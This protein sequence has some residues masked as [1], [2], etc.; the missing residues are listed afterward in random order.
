[1]KL[2]DKEVLVCDCE[3]T[4]VIDGK[5]LAKACQ[6]ALPE[7]GKAAKKGGAKKAAVKTPSLD[8]ATHLCRV[9]LNEFERRAKG[10]T[11]LLVACTQEAPVFLET[12]EEMGEDAPD[13]RFTNIRERAGWSKDAAKKTPATAKMAALLAEAAL[14]IPDAQSVTMIS[15]GV[16]LVLGKDETAIEAAKKV[17]SRL[18]VTVLLEP[19]APAPAPKLMDVPVFTGR[20]TAAQGHLGQFQVTVEDFAPATPSSKDSL[21]FEANAQNGTSVADLILDLRGG[22]PLFTAP[23]KRDGYMNPDPGNPALVADA[24]LELTDMVGEFDKPRYVDYDA[25]ICAH[26]RSGITGCT[27]C[28]DICPTGAITPDGDKVAIDAFVCAGCGTCA[29]VCPTGAAK[30]ALPAGDALHQRLRTLLTA[31]AAAGGGNPQLLVYDSGFGDDVIDAMARHG[32]GLPLNV[33]PFV[34]NQVA[35]VGLDFMLA[36][37]AFGA[38]RVL[39]LLPPGKADE[40]AS[41]ESE[42]ALAEAV[43]DGLG[44]GT[45]RI[46]V[47]EETDP[48]ALEARLYGLEPLN[49]MPVADFL[50]MGRKRAVMSLALA[51]L[52]AA[53]PNKVDTIALP[54]GAPFGAVEVDIPGCTVCLACVGACPT[55]ALRDNPDRPQLSFAEEACVQCGLCK[56]TC[57]EKVISLT[58]RL[59]FLE[60]ARTHQLVKEEEP[61][62]CIRCGKPFGA[63]ST[64]EN[65][66]KKLEGHA[67]FQDKGGVE[68]LKMCEDCRVIAI[69]EEDA[70]P[71]AGSARP[72]VRT[73][74]DYLRERDELREVA[75][76]DMKEK[77]LLPE[78]GGEDDEDGEDGGG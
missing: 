7:T 61:F 15:G 46:Q 9:Q 31:Y 53:A 19:G 52:H 41:L 29:S 44:Y 16:L 66:V 14:D 28:L 72:T 60:S 33:L 49:G 78:G 34:V 76:R 25:N 42:A 35:L 45:G 58:P 37:A 6:A 54:E 12:L 69:A 51:G 18:D 70:H 63:R 71:L 17:A 75:A 27:K 24:L 59:S 62:E 73:T 2:N 39:I 4:M 22:T 20:V 13:A 65:M 68:R 50:P 21:V 43:F 47:V 8:V 10:E 36:A 38:E 67:M 56:N 57:P 48:D 1:M 40:K 32:G 3:G 55:G 23:E 64:I 11:A 77:G 5:A 30:Y 26:A 74:E